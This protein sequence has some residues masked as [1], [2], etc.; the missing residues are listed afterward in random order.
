MTNRV[1]RLIFAVLDAMA[2][3]VWLCQVPPDDGVFGWPCVLD[4]GHAGPCDR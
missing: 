1:G 3:G 2:R 4:E